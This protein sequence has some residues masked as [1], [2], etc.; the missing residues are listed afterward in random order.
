MKSTKQT[1]ALG[2]TNP[3]ERANDA[4]LLQKFEKTWPKTPEGAN[5]H[6]AD[7][8]TPC[9]MLLANYKT[10]DISDFFALA[11]HLS[12]PSEETRMFFQ[13]FTTFLCEHSRLKQCPSCYD[14]AIY[15]VI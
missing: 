11:A 15:Q 12:L 7:F 2:Q 8:L 1:N 4:T 9:R 14:N 6:F 10:F 3:P 13:R 5:T